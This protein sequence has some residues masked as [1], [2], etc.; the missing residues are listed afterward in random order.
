MM[1]YKYRKDNL[2]T[3]R[4][5]WEREIYLSAPQEFNDPYDC[6]ARLAFFG[7]LKEWETH[8]RNQIGYSD[9]QKKQIIE[10]LRQHPEA[11]K[12]THQH[13]AGEATFRKNILIAC[14]SQN[15]KNRLMWSHYS[16]N[17]KGL[18]IGL[19]TESVDDHESVRFADEYLSGFM[20]QDGKNY[21]PSLAV[22]YKT[23]ILEINML[24]MSREDLIAVISQKDSIWKYE[25]EWRLFKRQESGERAFR[26]HV[27]AIREVYLGANMDES[28]VE[29]YKR[30]IERHNLQ[31]G[32]SVKLQRMRISRD[33]YDLVPED[34]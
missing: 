12:K 7:D 9:L 28:R 5:L 25:E 14:L 16:E 13:I 27:N 15:C 32:G 33:T 21:L 34:C 3:E 20:H 6:Y 1:L 23:T 22:V 8:I 24:R 31:S 2:H 29:Y 10:G 4:L 19:E 11:T 26:V 30:G 17:H 18:V